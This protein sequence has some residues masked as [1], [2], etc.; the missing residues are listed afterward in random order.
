MLDP[1]DFQIQ[2]QKLLIYVPNSLRANEGLVK[3]RVGEDFGLVWSEI[4]V[5]S[6]APPEASQNSDFLLTCALLRLEVVNL[7][8]EVAD[9]VRRLDFSVSIESA[10][11]D[12]EFG[13]SNSVDAEG[14][15]VGDIG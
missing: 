1:V 10:L 6:H 3:K 12:E 2:L 15:V 8:S 13:I 7:G 11:N 4:R 14:V 5:L 9:G